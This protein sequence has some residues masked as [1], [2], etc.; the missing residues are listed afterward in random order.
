MWR[1]AI[2][3]TLI[4]VLLTAVCPA[5]AQ[6]QSDDQQRRKERRET[7]LGRYWK[8]L[9]ER[10]KELVRRSGLPLKELREL[11]EAGFDQI[12]RLKHAMILEGLQRAS[13]NSWITPD[14]QQNHNWLKDLL[15]ELAKKVLPPGI[16][17]PIEIGEV[18]LEEME[19]Y[20]EDIVRSIDVEMTRR[21]IARRKQ[22]PNPVDAY[23]EPEGT[24]ANGAPKPWSNRRW[25]VITRAK[26]TLLER[27]KRD[28]PDG[29]TGDG[30]IPPDVKRKIENDIDKLWRQQM[31]NIYQVEQNREK[32][33][34]GLTEKARQE[35]ANMLIIRAI[36]DE[37]DQ[38]IRDFRVNAV[39][40]PP[41]S[42][43]RPPSYARGEA[44]RSGLC[45][46]VDW[47]ERRVRTGKVEKFWLPLTGGQWKLA[48]TAKGYAPEGVP[49]VI[50]HHDGGYPYKPKV[51]TIRLL[52]T[53]LQVTVRD[54]VSKR[55]IPSPRVELTLT[56]PK[57]SL[58]SPESQNSD[59]KFHDMKHPGDGVA[60]FDELPSG[61][62]TLSVSVEG[63]QPRTYR[64]FEYPRKGHR[65][66]EV[67][68]TPV[69]PPPVAVNIRDLFL[70][71]PA[72][73]PPGRWSG[74]EKPGETRFLRAV[75][76]E[77]GP[78]RVLEG[79][80][81]SQIALYGFGFDHDVSHVTVQIRKADEPAAQLLAAASQRLSQS[82][83]VPN[84]SGNGE[85]VTV[86]PPA[87]KP[88]AD[89]P[90]AILQDMVP[91]GRFW[92]AT[93]VAV[94]GGCAICIWVKTPK[95]LREVSPSKDAAHYL[96]VIERRMRGG[97]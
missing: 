91:D 45:V 13:E 54:A 23:D 77:E 32:I 82:Y 65:T 85:R 5:D 15:V 28:H 36:D 31:E 47:S 95:H 17:V 97:R 39:S 51:H 25:L 19:E 48:F 80:V 53:W 7:L 57:T 11:E 9:E 63:Y 92:N 6:S 89:Y 90:D 62:Y 4:V 87:P 14:D 81:M 55:T 22:T 86:R 68:L 21:Y 27:W 43:S 93:L 3:T 94:R 41:P 24:D 78:S 52:P 76:L 75:P 37:D 61:W 96:G 26:K 8:D 20:R 70:K 18:A 40:E 44:S 34:K 66:P 38:P 50:A 10:Q 56:K 42:V 84:P 88:F 12:A 2:L 72:E 1:S 73:L 16:T 35:L 30:E 69:A 74:E 83:T 46:L 58:T 67:E 79:Q 71:L 60:V 33:A 29:L 59:V 49:A 64:E